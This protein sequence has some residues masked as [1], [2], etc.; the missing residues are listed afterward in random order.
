MTTKVQV[1]LGLSIFSSLFNS[2]MKHVIDNMK[3]Q[4]L[5]CC[6]GKALSNGFKKNDSLAQSSRWIGIAIR[7]ITCS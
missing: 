5:E 7:T 6:N 1:T 2:K 3:Q 4:V